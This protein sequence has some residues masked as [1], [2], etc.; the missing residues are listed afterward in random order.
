MAR[1]ARGPGLP[2]SGSGVSDWL[3]N[4][5]AGLSFML[6]LPLL[7]ACMESTTAVGKGGALAFL[8]SK[9]P[10][11]P[12]TDPVSGPFPRSL[13]VLKTV[14][15]GETIDDPERTSFHVIDPSDPRRR[16][17]MLFQGPG[18]E[19]TLGAVSDLFGGWGLSNVELD[20]RNDPVESE[21]WKWYHFPSGKIGPEAG[22]SFWIREKIDG[23]LWGEIEVTGGAAL[24][25][26]HPAKG[27]RQRSQLVFSN[28]SW[29]QRGQVL[30]VAGKGKRRRVVDIDLRDGT[31]RDRAQFPSGFLS[32]E[33]S[34]KNDGRQTESEPS[35]PGIPTSGLLRFELRRAGEDGLLMI[36]DSLEGFDLWYHPNQ[37]GWKKVVSEVA[38]TKT[39][40]GRFPWLPV[41]YVGQGRFAVSRTTKDRVAIPDKWP[42]EEKRYGAARGETF[43]VN[44]ETGEVIERSPPFVYNHNPPLKIPKDW[45]RGGMKPENPFFLMEQKKETVSLFR[46]DDDRRVLSCGGK[47]EFSVDEESDYQIS[48]CGRFAAVYR[49]SSEREGEE[50]ATRRLRVIDGSSGES[51]RFENQS[52]FSNLFVS[53][54]WLN[55]VEPP[56]TR[57]QDE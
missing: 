34:L 5:R 15:R 23:W 1:K 26:H 41:A 2:G 45:W 43:L 22:K 9:V 32:L 44:G 8:E 46:W 30:G 17:R 37:G 33:E 29:D 35:I 13:L 6:V 40:G 52:E 25:R 47:G 24:I 38:I 39:F 54:F 48:G 56:G 51:W 16:V 3:M 27:M 19:Q 57:F 49:E 31:Y 11:P 36:T 18:S 42:E 28:L 55:L 21:V 10:G 7:V 50:K 4:K 53:A 20:Q 12:G 14:E